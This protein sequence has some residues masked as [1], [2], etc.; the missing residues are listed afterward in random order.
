MEIIGN[1]QPQQQDAHLVDAGGARAHA[2]LPRILVAED[3]ERVRRLLLMLLGSRWDVEAVED[4]Q[5]AWEAAKRD[6][7]DLILTDV[8]MPHVDGLALL[9]RL[10]AD[11]DTRDVPVVLLSGGAAGGDTISGLRA[12]ADDYIL[13]P[14]SA[15]E[16]IVRVESRL[17]MNAM[18]QRNARQ[19]EA[20][21]V[22]EAQRRWTERLLDTLPVPLLLLEPGSAEVRFA[23]RAARRLGGDSLAVGTP[24]GTSAAIRW[25]PERG[26][27]PLRNDELAPARGTLQ[28]DGADVVWER[29]GT[30]KALQADSELLAAAEG[31]PSTSVLTL[32]DVTP[33]VEAS[34][35]MRRALRARDEFLSV[36]SHELR[37]PLTTL[38]LQLEGLLRTMSG[39]TADEAV[40]R[41]LRVAR[42]QATRLEGLVDRLLDVSRIVGGALSLTLETVDLSEIVLQV[43]DAVRPQAEAVRSPLRVETVP[44]LVGQWDR[45]RL[46]Q[47]LLNILSNALKFGPGKPIEI[48]TEARA[49]AAALRVRDHGV[50][51]TAEQMARLFVRFE[52][53]ASECHYPGLGL[54][55][56]ISRQIVDALGGTITVESQPGEGAT[57]TVLLPR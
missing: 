54:G 35:E 21:A 27:R 56:W 23:N 44:G 45:R 9:R 43:A 7:P 1:E 10:R 48:R 53:A 41:R 33:L 3:D 22:L 2:P 36:A 42:A 5:R 16:L 52:R 13:K 24:L 19:A 31:R 38:G 29:E 30:T 4:G 18:R 17:E 14:F 40:T 11:A 46:E 50:G 8:F 32:R 25:P 12:G 34:E 55:L 51:M 57:F 28:L 26:G 37:T 20:L 6:R 15:D 39:G 47:V 49:G